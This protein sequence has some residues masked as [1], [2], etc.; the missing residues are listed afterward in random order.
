MPSIAPIFAEDPIE[1]R[2]RWRLLRSFFARWYG[3]PISLVGIRPNDA[4]EIEAAV[5]APL[6]P[7]VAEWVAFTHE[8]ATNGQ[9][10][11]A[12]T[13]LRDGRCIEYLPGL[14]VLSLQLQAEQDVRW[15]VPKEHL[16]EPDPAV[17]V[18]LL[19]H[20]ADEPSTFVP[21]PELD[22]ASVTAF[23]GNYLFAY[24]GCDGGFSA[25]LEDV[26]GLL[27]DMR[28]LEHPAGTFAHLRIFEGAGWTAVLERNGV[29][30]SPPD[31]VV[32]ISISMRG[33]VQVRDLP[34][35]LASLR[36]GASWYSSHV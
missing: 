21:A 6:G 22:V 27:E 34:R 9:L 26:D 11:D 24:L 16:H 18:H 33:N 14:R 10:R 23:A 32:R 15:V 20:V 29:F 36:A 28:R 25:E 17:R 30:C 31:D 5:G 8:L 2:A 19:D 7:A 13:M 1:P 4:D 12:A 35:P 3:L